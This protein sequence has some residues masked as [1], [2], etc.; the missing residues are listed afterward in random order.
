MPYSNRHGQYRAVYFRKEAAPQV[1]HVDGHP[2]AN[3]H[4]HHVD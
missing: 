1:G 2:H 3:L 4:S